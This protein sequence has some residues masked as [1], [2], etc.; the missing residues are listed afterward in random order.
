[1]LTRKFTNTQHSGG[2][3]GKANHPGAAGVQLIPVLRRNNTAVLPLREF[4]PL[5]CP[6][7]VPQ[8]QLNDFLGREPHVQRSERTVNPG[9]DHGVKPELQ[10]QILFHKP[11]HLPDLMFI[12]RKDYGLEHHGEA[13]L[14]E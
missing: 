14:H 7:R 13:P 11:L 3:N 8:V 12:E 5:F 1:M 4:F 10:A 2:V 6:L 9:I